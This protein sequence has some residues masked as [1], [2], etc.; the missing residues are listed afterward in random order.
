MSKIKG[1]VFDVDGTLLNT[2]EHIVQAFE[3]VLPEHG[4]VA[5]REAIRRV[6]GMTLIDCY[7]TLV[8]KGNHEAMRAKHHEVQQTPEM[9]AL[10]VAYDGLHEALDELKGA[11]IKTA[12]QTNR[13]RE[14]IDLIFDHI[15]ITGLFGTIITPEDVDEPKPN[16]AGINL[17]ALRSKIEPADMMMVGDTA[18]DIKTAQAAGMRG[19]VG[20]THGF[21]TRAELE[22]AGATVI[23]DGFKELAKA[24]N[25]QN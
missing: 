3:V 9:Y 16:S 25:E 11:G 24:I 15:G 21:G 13:S 18:I 17:I 23:I 1:V 2:F 12:I 10:I 8:P 20:V 14:S 6:I 4:A 5:D 19:S 22:A 7:K